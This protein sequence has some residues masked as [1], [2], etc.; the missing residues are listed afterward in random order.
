MKILPV[1]NPSVNVK[2]VSSKGRVGFD[3]ALLYKKVG[4]KWLDTAASGRYKTMEIISTCLSFAERVILLK[5][6]TQ[7]IRLCAEMRNYQTR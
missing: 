2:T 5:I 6:N 7:I 3:T 1:Q 4:D